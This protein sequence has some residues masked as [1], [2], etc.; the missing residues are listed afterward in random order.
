MSATLRVVGLSLVLAVVVSGQ[1]AAAETDGRPESARRPSATSGARSTSVQHTTEPHAALAAGDPRRALEMLE[2]RTLRL[3]LAERHSIEGR[4][5]FL[6][7]DY[8]LAR[9]KLKSATRLRPAHAWDLYWLGRAYAASGMPALA[10]TNFQEAHWNGLETADLH[11]HWALVLKSLNESLGK[12]SQRRWPNDDTQ[13]TKPGTRALGGLVVGPVLSRPG[14]VIISPPNSAIYQVHRAIA[15]DPERGDALLLCGEIWAAADRHETAV[16][17]FENAARRLKEEDLTQCHQC[18]AA[19]L[20]AMGDFDGYLTQTRKSMRL[21]GGV[22]SVL[23]AQ[24]Y[25]RVARE[26]AR[27]GDLK[28]QIRYLTL[29]AEL[30]PDVDRLIILADAL[31]QA[32][33]SGDA[34]GYLRQALQH[35]PT[36]GQRRKIQQ[37]LQ[38]TAYLSGSTR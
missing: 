11:Y 14:W 3:P 16:S 36:R 20:L 22:D 33:R 13:P 31:L 25:D 8:A 28:R 23:L 12:I 35:N 29:S 34:A 5:R 30:D 24:C 17:M 2:S 21:T 9:R 18:W 27:R 4:A 6:L 10:A 38:L 32:Q 7:G 26:V 15:L 1:R 37:R 19:S